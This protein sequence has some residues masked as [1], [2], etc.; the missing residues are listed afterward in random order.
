MSVLNDQKRKQSVLMLMSVAAGLW[1]LLALSSF[2]GASTSGDHAKFGQPVLKDFAETRGDTQQIRFTMADD[3]YTLLRT[4]DGWVMKESGNYPIRADRLSQLASDLEQL[5]FD[6]ARTS[7]PYKFNQLGLGSPDE[8]GNG[9]L[10]EIFGPE[11]ELSE[12]LIIGRKGDRIY[13]RKPGDDQTYR[14]QGDL[15]PFYNRR[16]WLDFDIIDIDPS[17]IRSV[18]ITDAVGQSVYLRRNPGADER[19]FRPAPPHQDDLVRDRLA[20]SSTAL[21]ITRL[22]ARDAKPADQLMT[23]AVGQ[24]ISETFDGLEIDLKAYR[25]PDGLWVTMRAVEAGEGARRAEDINR[26]A[27]GWAFRIS[28]YDFQDFTPLVSRLVTRSEINAP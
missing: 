8:D 16:A 25:E 19:N 15:P 17:A 7:D 13:V 9:V 24:H 1:L 22:S 2:I 26:K 10:V 20:I 18:R 27:E 28:D 23:D 4:S 21:A 12:E 14:T 3:S 11:G 6:E 5:A